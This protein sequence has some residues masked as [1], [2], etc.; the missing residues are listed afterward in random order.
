MPPRILV[1]DDRRVL[2]E[3]VK[4]FLK[5]EGFD[6]VGEASNGLEAVRLAR[7]LRPDVAV[8]D[9]AMPLA[10]GLTA[11]RKILRDSPR[12]RTILLTMHNE[13]PYIM[14]ALRV[15]IQGYVLKTQAADDLLVAIE[16]VGKGEI[17]LSPPISEILAQ[18]GVT[19]ADLPQRPYP[20]PRV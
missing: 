17:Y 2:R 6:V 7:S 3:G 12:T 4:A 16:E 11:A 20:A 10:N 5:R 1:A 9:L 8:L 18:L 15:G 19:T 13:A 14:E